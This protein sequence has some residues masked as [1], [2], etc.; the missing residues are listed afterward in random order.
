MDD[1]FPAL[2]CNISN[3]I[4]CEVVKFDNKQITNFT[5]QWFYDENS[6]KANKFTQKFSKSKLVKFPANQLL[7]TLLCLVFKETSEVSP[8][9]LQLYKEGLVQKLDLII[10]HYL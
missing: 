9:R 3:S 2:D 5:N 10:R 1:T 7:L 8:N 6:T 4:D